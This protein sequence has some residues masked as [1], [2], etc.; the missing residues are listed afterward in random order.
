MTRRNR[1]IALAFALV[2]DRRRRRASSIADGAEDDDAP[3][4]GTD[5]D[6]A[7]EAALAHTGGGTV[8]ESEIGDDGAAYGIEIRRDDG[9]VVEVNLDASFAVIGSEPDEDGAADRGRR[10][11][12]RDPEPGAPR[13]AA[14]AGS[15][16]PRWRLCCWSVAAPGGQHRRRP[17]SAA[18][19]RVAS[20]R[21]DSAGRPGHARLLEPDRDHEPA[22]PRVEP[23]IGPAPRDGGGPALPHRGH[24]A[25]EPAHHRVAGQQVATLVS[26]YVAFLDGRLARGRLRLSTPRPMT[27]RSGTSARTSST[28]P[29]A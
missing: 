27:G 5:L 17:I 1:L 12:R 3:L 2:G 18:R 21:A 4:T 13:C 10:D 14:L 6:R 24:A 11:R 9:S 8:I 28:S 25:A 19:G 29:T 23:G 20:G 16:L 26:Q 22:V 15:S 7:T